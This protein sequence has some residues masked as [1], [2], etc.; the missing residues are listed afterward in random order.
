MTSIFSKNLPSDLLIVT[1]NDELYQYA[2][3]ISNTR[4]GHM[5][6]LIAYCKNAKHVSYCVNQCRDNKVE[7][8]IRSGGHQ[9]EGMSSGQGVVIID[10]TKMNQIDYRRANRAW[11]PAGMQLQMTYD[12]LEAK[13]L[14]IPGGACQSVNVGGLTQ[15]GGWEVWLNMRQR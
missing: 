11:M 2:R 8:R 6:L 3:V 14:T 13:G 1:Q 4:F 10:V 12:D 9:H 5:P 7:F 15:G